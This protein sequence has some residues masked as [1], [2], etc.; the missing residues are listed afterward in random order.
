M[1]YSQAILLAGLISATS[2]FGA[3]TKISMEQI[4]KSGIRGWT[5]ATAKNYQGAW[6]NSC[7]VVL[8]PNAKKTEFAA[9]YAFIDLWGFVDHDSAVVLRSIGARG[10]Y[11]WQKFS[12]SSGKLLEDYFRSKNTDPVPSWVK[13][14]LPDN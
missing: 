1:L 7:L 3:E 13:P 11:R 2:C 14:F 9:E 8:G 10:P 6:M 5:V 12:L 4:S